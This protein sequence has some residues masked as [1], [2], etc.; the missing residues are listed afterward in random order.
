MKILVN[1]EPR[2]AA[3]GRLDQL[4][5]ELGYTDPHIAT[6]LN[7]VFVPRDQRHATP[8]NDGDRVEILA[9]MQGG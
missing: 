8:V 4:L 5:E 2:Q 6:A 1:G 9:P 3:S 7:E